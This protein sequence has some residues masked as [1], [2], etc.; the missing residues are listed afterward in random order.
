MLL[1][2][3]IP[4]PVLTSV[5]R[6]CKRLSSGDRF[7]FSPGCVVL[8]PGRFER[9]GGKYVLARSSREPWFARGGGDRPFWWHGRN[10]LVALRDRCA[11]NDAHGW[12]VGLVEGHRIDSR[13]RRLGPTL[14]SILHKV[15]LVREQH[16]NLDLAGEDTR[17]AAGGRWPCSTCRDRP[18]RQRSQL[19]CAGS[20]CWP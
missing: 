20:A 10:G 13:R 3:S 19:S 15:E 17:E 12:V 16:G 1:C 7:S 2:A 6:P 8:L 9:H 4:P 5:R 11:V 18:R 14:V